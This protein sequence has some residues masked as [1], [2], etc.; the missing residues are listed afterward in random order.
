M[1]AYNWTVLNWIAIGLLLAALVP[2]L[3]A[4]AGRVRFGRADGRAARVAGRAFAVL[5]V[6]AL[7]QAV[8]QLM[9]VTA[10]RWVVSG[11]G[12]VFVVVGAVL[13]LRWRV[14]R[15]SDGPARQE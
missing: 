3:L 14:S 6:G 5:D 1:R 9:G 2:A 8:A 10:A 4:W 12:L 7:L 11:V 13:I 15:T